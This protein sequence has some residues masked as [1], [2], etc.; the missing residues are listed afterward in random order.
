[1]PSAFVRNLR[2]YVD[3]DVSMRTHV[4]KTVLSCIA[5]LRHLRSTRRSVSQPVM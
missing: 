2:I 4:A 3:A 5:V 1:M